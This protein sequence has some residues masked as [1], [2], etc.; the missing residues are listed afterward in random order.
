VKCGRAEVKAEKKQATSRLQWKSR[1]TSSNSYDFW[2]CV[3]RFW[4]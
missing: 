4:L 2:A 3:A 1:N